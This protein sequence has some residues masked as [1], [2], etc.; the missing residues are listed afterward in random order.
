MQ[1]ED[2]ANVWHGYMGNDGEAVVEGGGGQ[3]GSEEGC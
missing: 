2:V 3:L 1:N